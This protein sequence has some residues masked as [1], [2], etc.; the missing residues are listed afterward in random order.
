MYEKGKS[1]GGTELMTLK[2]LAPVTILTTS[3]NIFVEQL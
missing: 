3:M 1:E 2:Y